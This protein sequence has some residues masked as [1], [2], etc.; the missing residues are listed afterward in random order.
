M[1][2]VVEDS[3]DAVACAVTMA[4]RNIGYVLTDDDEADSTRCVV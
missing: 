1:N 2:T 3:Q 4:L